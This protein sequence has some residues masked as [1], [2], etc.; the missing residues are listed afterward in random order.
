LDRTA[1][2]TASD[3]EAVQTKPPPQSRS[4]DRVA[5]LAMTIPC[6]SKML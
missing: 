3:S 2:V 4:L 6:N 1:D 5:W